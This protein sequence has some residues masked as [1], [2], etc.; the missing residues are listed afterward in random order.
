MRAAGPV[1]ISRW[2]PA[3]A[4]AA[5][6]GGRRRERR[7]LPCSEHPFTTSAGPGLARRGREGS[8]RVPR[9][10]SRVRFSAHHCTACGQRRPAR[11]YRRL[12]EGGGGGFGYFFFFHPPSSPPPLFQPVKSV[13]PFEPPAQRLRLH[14]HPHPPR[15]THTPPR[16]INK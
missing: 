16:A 2:G 12:G 9:W 8:S 4:G 14:T 1:V 10:A 11:R 6:Q 15:H 13:C 7:E 3:G 5:P